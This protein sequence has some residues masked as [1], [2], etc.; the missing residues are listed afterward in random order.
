MGGEQMGGL[1][2]VSFFPLAAPGLHLF[3]GWRFVF[4]FF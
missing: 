3:L 2:L 1:V 4:V